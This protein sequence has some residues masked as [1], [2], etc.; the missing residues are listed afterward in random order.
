MN[1][2]YNVEQE[3]CGCNGQPKTW[4]KIFDLLATDST[5]AVR[6]A[7]GR[8]PPGTVIRVVEVV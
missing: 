4:S 3:S 8:V 5:D 6:Q 1:K 7:R 2:W